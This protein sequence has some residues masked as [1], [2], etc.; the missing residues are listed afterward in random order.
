MYLDIFIAIVLLFALVRGL[1]NGLFKELASTIGFLLGL[2]VA[3]TCYETLGE[4][5][6]VDG[7]EVNMLTSIVAFLLLWI[8]VPIVCGLL[9]TF[10]TKVI[11][12]SALGTLNRIGGGLLSMAKFL[13]LISCVLNVMA[14]LRILNK[15]RAEGSVMAAPVQSITKFA[16]DRAADYAPELR[17]MAD[18]FFINREK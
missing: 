3:A 15:E 18:T 8:V 5:L 12:D 17:E 14:E 13:V 1:M 10:L 7:S 2:L 11:K 4:Y 16:I 6:T 9:A